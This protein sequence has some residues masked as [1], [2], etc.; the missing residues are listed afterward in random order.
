MAAPALS[1]I[2]PFRNAG[3][4]L[5]RALRSCLEQTFNDFEI[6]AVDDASTDESE[7]LAGALA[8]QDPRLRILHHSR[9]RGVSAAFQTGLDQANAPLIARMDADDFALPDKF[10]KQIIMLRE[11]PNLAGVSCRVRIEKIR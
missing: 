5:E 8:S 1:I 4:F 11:N 9:H 7:K 10:A 6:V 2:L 3:A